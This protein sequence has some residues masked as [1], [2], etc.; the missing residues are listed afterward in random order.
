MKVAPEHLRE[1][2]D[3]HDRGQLLRAYELSRAHGPLRRWRGAAGRVLAGRL[4]MNLGAPH[5]GRVSHRLA[6]RE[7]PGHPEA[8]YYYARALFESHGPLRAWEFLRRTGELPDDA[9]PHVRADW[10]AFHGFVAS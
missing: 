3:E 8:R 5:L 9:P 10:L 1:I 7:E 4:A 6:W 2:L